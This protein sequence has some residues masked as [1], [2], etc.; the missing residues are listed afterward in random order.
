MNVEQDKYLC[1]RISSWVGVNNQGED[2]YSLL[3]YH[4]TAVSCG[5]WKYGGNH[6][7]HVEAN[8]LPLSFIFLLVTLAARIE[9]ILEPEYVVQSYGIYQIE[10]RTCS[11]R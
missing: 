11:S 4:L 6:L 10:C 1:R 2:R 8:D 3:P 7:V 9:Q 5:Y